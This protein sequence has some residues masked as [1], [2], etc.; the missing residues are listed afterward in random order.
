VAG[1]LE[2]D[3]SVGELVGSSL[4][5]PLEQLGRSGV[6]HEVERE[7]KPAIDECS[8]RAASDQN[9]ANAAR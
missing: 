5:G 7:W 2:A 8:A 4:D 1:Q 3:P 6:G 9:S